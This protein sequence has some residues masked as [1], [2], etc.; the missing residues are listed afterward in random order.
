MPK[1]KVVEVK[2]TVEVKE[3]ECLN[4]ALVDAEKELADLRELYDTL[5][6]RNIHSLSEVEVKIQQQDLLVKALQNK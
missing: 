3:C 1:K 5:L 6:T 4:Q 2:G